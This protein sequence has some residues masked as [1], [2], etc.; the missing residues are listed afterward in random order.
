MTPALRT[1]MLT[2]HVVF[3]VGWVGAVIG[4]LVLALAG[5]ISQD[6]ETAPAAYVAMN[7][8]GWFAIVPLAFASLL[9]GLIQSL[10]TEWGLFRHYWVTIKFLLTVFATAVLMVHTQLIGLLAHAAANGALHSTDMGAAR[11]QLVIAAGAGLAV[12]LVITALSIYKP[13]G[14]TRYGLRKQQHYTP[15]QQQQSSP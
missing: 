5:L 8:T 12:L 14:R 13:R 6:P 9:T 1:F 7:L 11:G 15:R 10:G 2:A 4:F 3:S